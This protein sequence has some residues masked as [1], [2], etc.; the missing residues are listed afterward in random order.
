MNLKYKIEKYQKILRA[1]KIAKII[2]SDDNQIR[3]PFISLFNN[4]EELRNASVHYSPE[5]SRI[6]LKPHDWFDKATDFSKLVIEA[7]IQIW[8]SCH[9]KNK[10]PD[11]LGR[12]EYDILHKMAKDREGKINKIKKTGCNNIP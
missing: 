8:K 12:L 1:D 6:W 2:L 7:S 11:Y 3:E 5:K 9:D 10:G 4:Y